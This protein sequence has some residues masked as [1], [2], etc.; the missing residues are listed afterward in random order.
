MPYTSLNGQLSKTGQAL[1]DSLMAFGC[2]IHPT[3]SKKYVYSSDTIQ[4]YPGSREPTSKEIENCSFWLDQELELVRPKIVILLGR[5]AAQ[6]FLKKH[7]HMK[8]K[9]IR[10]RPYWG[11]KLNLKKWGESRSLFCVPHPSYRRRKPLGV[12]RI[13]RRAAFQIFGIV[14]CATW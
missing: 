5:I 4:C 14:R 12:G 10:V 6:F 7:L 1:N 2:A 13:Y 9:V 3:S 11:K 8:T